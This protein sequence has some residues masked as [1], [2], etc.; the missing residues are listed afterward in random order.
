[1]ESAGFNLNPLMRQLLAPLLVSV[2][3]FTPA[4]CVLLLYFTF[5]CDSDSDGQAYSMSPV[6]GEASVS[7]RMASFCL[8]EGHQVAALVENLKAAEANMQVSITDYKSTLTALGR[9]L[10]DS[11]IYEWELL[12]QA[13]T[14][15]R[16]EL[17]EKLKEAFLWSEKFRLAPS[18][19][20]KA[21]LAARISEGN[22]LAAAISNR[23]RNLTTMKMNS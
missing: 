10:D 8:G 7:Q 17:E 6:A 1:M 5:G 12:A 2:R 9:S 16:Q 11:T 18:E 22:A 14:K 19:G 3:S 23:Y 15:D 13:L 20:H 4:V 21:E